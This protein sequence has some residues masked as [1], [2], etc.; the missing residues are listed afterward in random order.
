M[1]GESISQTLRDNQIKQARKLFEVFGRIE[2]V[3]VNGGEVKPW[4]IDSVLLEVARNRERMKGVAFS[5][6]NGVCTLRVAMQSS[7][8]QRRAL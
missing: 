1:N 4:H 7:V 6:I 3:F 2:K 5:K 8:P